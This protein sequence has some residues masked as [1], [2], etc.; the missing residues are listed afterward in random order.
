M[1][2]KRTKVQFFQAYWAGLV[3][4]HTR[5]NDEDLSAGQAAFREKPVS[6]QLLSEANQ[7]VVQKSEFLDWL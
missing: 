3:G 6:F 1:T 4:T 2:G 7:P 5:I